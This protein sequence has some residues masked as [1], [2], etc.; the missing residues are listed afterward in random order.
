MMK[1]D[2]RKSGL[3]PIRIQP[4]PRIFFIIKKSHQ[5]DDQQFVESSFHIC[6]S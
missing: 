5:T 6:L 3:L 2:Y 4:L 1:N